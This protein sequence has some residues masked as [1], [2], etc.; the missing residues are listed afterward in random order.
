MQ[1]ITQEPKNYNK[2]M[3]VGEA[4]GADEMKKRIP[5][6]GNEGQY[7]RDRLRRCKI[8][9][10]DCFMTYAIHEKYPNPKAIEEGKIALEIDI[11]KWEPNII[12]AVGDEA[13]KMLT[14]EESIFKYRGFIMPCT[15]VDGYKVLPTIHPGNIFRGNS[16]YDIVLQMDLRKALGEADTR[17]IY[18]PKRDIEVVHGYN[19]A[20]KLLNDLAHCTE[21]HA[22]DIETAGGWM[23]AYGIATSPSQAYVIPKELLD[24]PE[25]TQAVSRYAASPVPK[26][27]HNALYDVFHNAYYYGIRNEN[28]FF[29]TMIG[30][31]SAFPTLPKS[32]AFCASIYTQ[33]PY[34]KCLKG[35]CEV[36]TLNG[37]KRFKDLNKEET[38][39]VS[40]FSG[41]LY[42]DKVNLIKYKFEGYGKSINTLRHNCW[43]TKN[44]RILN[45]DTHKKSRRVTEAN[46]MTGRCNIV[47]A[48]EYSQGTEQCSYIKLLVAIQAD[49]AVRWDRSKEVYFNLTKERKIKRLYEICEELG[50]EISVFNSGVRDRLE[51]QVK[52]DVVNEIVE[53]L[54]RDK[55]F[56]SYML[57]YN[58]E[59]LNAFLQELVL[60]D[61]WITYN[62]AALNYS[63]NNYNNIE[64]VATISHLCGYTAHVMKAAGDKW[65]CKKVSMK[66]TEYISVKPYHIK[67]EYYNGDVYCVETDPGFFLCRSNENIFITGN[68]EGKEIIKDLQRNKIVDWPAFYIYNG[69]DCCLTHEI[70]PKIQEEIDFWQTQ[71]TFDLM[72]G[73]VRPALF[74]MLTG[75]RV[76]HDKVSAFADDNERS[77]EVLTHIKDETIGDIN[78]G[79][80]VQLKKYLY[81]DLD[82]PKQKFKGKVTSDDK[83]L[84]KL[85]SY[86][87]P[88]KQRI[89]LIR[90]I[91]TRTK[92]RDF[93]KVKTNE[94]GRVRFSMNI[95]GTYTGR[96]ASSKS[97]TG[98]GFN[99]QNQPK[100]IRMFYEADPGRI[101][102]QMDLSNAEARVVAAL[103]GD[104]KWLRDFDIRD[105]HTFVA[106]Q[107]FGVPFEEVTK[108]Q[109]NKYAKKVA[110]A[111]HY[112]LG[113]SLLSKIL[114]CSAKEAK[115]H[116]SEYY[117]IRPK[118]DDWHHRINTDV[119]KSRYI[120]TCFG[121]VIQFFGPFFDSMI[122]DAV[123]AE[124]QSTS[125]DYLGHAI[126]PISELSPIWFHLQ[127]HDS[128]LV[129][130]P[131]SLLTL[132]SV[133]PEMKEITE[134]EIVVNGLPMIIPCDFEIGYN[135]KDLKE[136]KDLNNIKQVYESLER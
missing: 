62:G 24:V 118:L 133:M 100:D 128:V 65:K 5:F 64:W 124:P 71:G 55:N 93:Y 47:S 134:Q 38:I 80:H 29:D 50:V 25:V 110:H 9:P 84:E 78:V 54:G 3:I 96:W 56:G 16:R 10:S 119:R 28:I 30:Q 82:M 61:G 86:P 63:S 12:I 102:I 34:W 130:V 92:R 127:V 111:T 44:H 32:L 8:D 76:N 6:V 79:S 126:L 59:T 90:E 112:L 74:A 51:C 7:L 115:Q 105:Q 121:R 14:S 20:I 58:K 107:L 52:G 116:K 53:L 72:M 123:A 46:D 94:D 23:V 104:E 77:L 15:L 87:T 48:G 91:K 66:K 101:F 40:T 89:G 97:I 57:N 103:C 120:R 1:K 73:C 113:W 129:S 117:R 21:P 81:E 42:F 106:S 75:F 37:W 22:V 41:H 11:K 132:E 85:E 4:P 67:D 45:A 83:A 18:Y 131:D 35:D 26:M 108:I 33:Q 136:V 2:I 49:A 95:C 36:L 98:S 70:W 68:S 125:A 60:W 27:F 19:T 114:S 39:M 43:Y 88:H 69:K 109:R 99:M 17:S 31:H 13:L 135:W 122:T